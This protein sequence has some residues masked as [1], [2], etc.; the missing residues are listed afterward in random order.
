MS[1]TNPEE[2]PNRKLTEKL[3]QEMYEGYCKTVGG[4]SWDG[5]ELPSWGAFQADSDKQ[6]QVQGWIYAA[7]IAIAKLY[8]TAQDTELPNDALMNMGRRP[9]EEEEVKDIGNPTEH[10]QNRQ[11]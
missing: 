8:P 4:R 9:L 10:G 6:L 1:T 11:V 5:N 3:A 7:K 2:Y